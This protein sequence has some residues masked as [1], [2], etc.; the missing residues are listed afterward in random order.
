MQSNK[1]GKH[2]WTF[3]HTLSFNYPIVPMQCD[4][5]NYKKFFELIKDMLPCNVCKKSFI[6]FYNNLPI[7]DYLDDRNGVVYWLYTMHNIVNLKLDTNVFDFKELILKYENRRARCGN[8]NT[9]D[10]KKLA[11]CQKYI[12]WN[13]EMEDF[14]TQTIKKYESITIKRIG[15]LIKDNTKREEI[16]YILKML[17]GY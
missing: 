4:R 14:R 8:I 3:F 12:E 9:S 10:K 16:K 11:E 15:K 7:D 5:D 2:A 17:K 6:F 1:W 13:K